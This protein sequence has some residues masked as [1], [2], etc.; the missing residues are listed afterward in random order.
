MGPNEDVRDLSGGDCNV[1]N[2]VKCACLL[3]LTLGLYW[4]ARLVILRYKN[5]K[6]DKEYTSCVLS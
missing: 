6:R 4:A 2:F 3:S 1:P 5:F